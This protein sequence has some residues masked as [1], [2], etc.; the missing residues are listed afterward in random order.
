MNENKL[1]IEKKLVGEGGYAN[2]YSYN[3][4]ISG[5]K[6]AI[7]KLKNDVTEKEIERFKLEF[8]RMHNISSPYIVEVYNFYDDNKSYTMEWCDKTLEK[9]IMENNNKDFMTFNFRKKIVLQLFKALKV[10]HSKEILHRDLS[11][12]NI[13]VKEYDDNVILVK[14]SDFGISKD[15]DLS[16]T[17]TNS[18]IR[19]TIID[20][21]LSSFNDYNFKNELFSIGIITNFI[22]TGKKRYVNNHNELSKIIEKCIASDHKNRYDNLEDMLNDINRLEDYDK[23]IINREIKNDIINFSKEKLNKNELD[24]FSLEILY[25]AS[26][27]NG[28]ILKVR[29]LMGISIN[30]G[31]KSY[32]PKSPKEEAYFEN[33]IENLVSLGY[34]RDQNGKDE[35]FKLTVKSYNL[36]E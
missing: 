21:T 4:P 24:D 16:L 18:E 15:L 12:R 8:E 6:F 13:L 33:I 29:T 23:K 28:T 22:F 19:G 3:E 36:F 10:I 32:S 17:S 1:M 7:K 27:S 25:N 30:C 35:L 9:Y 2:V 34:I 31:N 20:Y 14:I 5:K 26:I 11:F